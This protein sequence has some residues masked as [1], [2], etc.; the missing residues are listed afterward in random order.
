[1]A[2][3]KSMGLIQQMLGSGGLVSIRFPVFAAGNGFCVGWP[4]AFEKKTALTSLMF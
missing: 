1:M 2:V 3:F 4:P